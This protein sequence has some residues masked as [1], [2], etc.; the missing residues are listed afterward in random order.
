MS[1]LVP[2]TLFGWIPFVI[3]LF[4]LMPPRRA[5][6]ASFLLA[7]LFLPM[8]G[9]GVPGL[10]DYT[11]MSATTFGVLIGAALFDTDRLLGWRPKWVDIPM[12][13]WCTC[14]LVSSYLNGLGLYDGFSEIVRAFISWGLPYVIGR[15]YFTDLEGL[16]ELAIGIFIG[17]LIYVPFCWF[18]ARMSPQLHVW[19]YG[20]R[21]HSFHQN[22]RDGGYR[23]MVFMQHGL[24]VG[25]WMG[26]TTMIGL[27]L[28]RSKTVQKVWDIPMYVLIPAMFLTV[29]LCKS[30]YAV[31]L[32]ATGMAALF[33]T[34][35]LR[36]KLIMVAL[37]FVPLTYTA[38]RASGAM[39]GETI[40]A[41]AEAAFGEE[42]S[43]SAAMRLNNEN[44]LAARAMQKPVWGW[45]GWGKARVQD[46]RG[47]DLITDSLWIITLGKYGWVGLL[48]IMT[49]LLLPM[50]LVVMD[51]RV[52]LWHHPMVAPVVA[53][54]I[55]CTLY[56]FDHLMNG[57]VNPIFMLA[58]GAVGSAHYCF[59]EMAKRATPI[60]LAASRRP[61][62]GA[63]PRP[64]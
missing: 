33:A 61:M 46:E 35:M 15:V 50:I 63:Q 2:I 32:L 45:G 56:M 23:P 62:F 16:R 20:F 40:I 36:T 59:P 17:G 34:K 13:V 11:K 55:V 37:L 52:E 9:Y 1:A 5:V 25:M 58:A 22:V 24:M 39:T 29:Y 18:E 4:V 14:P 38:L 30:K 12:L 53:L 26:M 51:W 6:I 27:W 19:V 7:W 49:T 3:L 48:A 64:A 21:Q 28:W 10:P 47:R 44:P 41:A 54:A 31:L 8:A 57:M 60:Q 43:K 42:R